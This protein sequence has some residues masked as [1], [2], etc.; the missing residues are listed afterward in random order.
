MALPK[1][2]RKYDPISPQ[3]A[4]WSFLGA[5]IG[6]AFVAFIATGGVKAGTIS[7]PD[8]AA[9]MLA[10]VTLVLTVLGLAIAVAAIYGYKAFMDKSETTAAEIAGEVA[11]PAAIQVVKD[12]IANN[13]EQ[14]LIAQAEAVALRVISPA[15]LQDLIREQIDMVMLGN[16]ADEELDRVE[17]QIAGILDTEAMPRVNDGR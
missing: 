6:A 5:I 11:V 12:Y 7:Y 16:S 3:W 9:V 4:L 13:A 10:S 2:K 17:E 1:T 15:A 8:L 14:V